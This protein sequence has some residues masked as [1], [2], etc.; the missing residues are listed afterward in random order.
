MNRFKSW[1]VRKMQIKGHIAYYPT[2][3]CEQGN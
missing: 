2:E 1:E 3:D